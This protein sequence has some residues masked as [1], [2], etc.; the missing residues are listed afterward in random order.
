MSMSLTFK[1]QPYEI[2]GWTILALPKDASLQLPSR[3]QVMIKGTINGHALHTALEPDGDSGHW[4][5]IDEALQRATGLSAGDTA[6]LDVIATKE[7][8]EPRVPDDLQGAI[9]ADTEVR[10]RW[11]DITPMARW[12]WI[13][14][15]NSTN[16]AETRARRI[17]VSCSKLLG[18]SRR[19]CCFNRSMCC[20]PDVSKNGVLLRPM[21][22]IDK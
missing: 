12:E 2:N 8:P 10:E 7:W 3:G 17:E 4:L 5:H 14:W 18:G 21:L 9:D 13:R 22:A 1:A 15:I 20:V 16:Q 19:P 11:A 6:E